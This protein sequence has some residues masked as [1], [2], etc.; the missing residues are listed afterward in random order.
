MFYLNK[1]RKR[2]KIGIAIS[3][4]LFTFWLFSLPEPLFNAPCSTV[5]LDNDGQLM[6]ARLAA[7]GQWRFPIPDSTPHKM[8]QCILTFEDKWFRKHPGVNLISLFRATKQNIQSG[9]IVSGG[10]TL[11]MQVIRLS[12]KDKKR[13]FLE[14]FIEMALAL[15]L[16]LRY[17]KDEILNLY[18]TNAPFGGNTVGIQTASWRYFGRDCKDLSWAEASTLAVLPN[19]PALIHPGKNRDR[20]LRKRNRLLAK[21]QKEGIIDEETC[22]LAISEPLPE[23]PKSL[24]KMA[25]HL[26]DRIA[27]RDN[28]QIIR[29]TIDGHLQQKIESTVSYFHDIYT[30]NQVQNMA[31]VVARTGTG[32]VV[33][34]CGNA[35]YDEHDNNHVDIITSP[36]STGSTLKPFLYNAILEEGTL[37]PK[38]LIPDIPI[39]IAGYRPNN[40]ERKFDGA[41]P[42]NEALARS[43]NIPAVLML[44][45]YGIPKFMDYLK[46]AGMTTLH[47]S[48]DHYGLTL[49]LGGAEGT[50]WN[51]TGMY[52]NMTRTLLNYEKSF[53]YSEDDIH[54]LY[55]DQKN[56]AKTERKTQR[57]PVLF[58]AQ[59][60]W[61]TLDAI[62][63][64][65]RPGVTDWRAFNSSRRVGWKTGTSF[66]NKDAWAIGVTP[67]Y[68]VGVWIGN[69]DGEGRPGVTG[70]TYAA[71]VM[72]SIFNQLPATSWF[73]QPSKDMVEI[74]VCPQS[75]YRRGP[76]CPSGETVSVYKTQ[77][78]CEACPFHHIV[79]LSPDRKYRVTSTCM[80]VTEMRHE[81]WFTLPPSMEWYYKQHNTEYKSQPPYKE[82]CRAR[83][84]ASP[85]EFIYPKEDSKLFIPIDLD[86]KKSEIIF[87]IAHQD[88]N[89]IL[90]W[91][92]DKDYLGSTTR[93]HQKG[94]NAEI[95]KHIMTVTDNNGNAI[96]KRFEIVN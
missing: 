65:N 81:K 36:R 34:Y 42:A 50:L 95:G 76:N 83:N 79:H 43:L 70:V 47:Y 3:F 94:I 11:S 62:K 45:D 39:L 28:R 24:Q 61:Q 82:G 69:A 56:K 85:M 59:A 86:G 72:F 6:G 18:L 55:F 46:K 57:Q 21:L 44:R 87:E 2:Y 71:P 91:H 53:N 64:L 77:T 84:E 9:H 27:R 51:L 20:L 73:N 40:F 17:T 68:V 14:K 48:A 54:P 89:A 15:R 52:A 13:T 38:T 60:V 30:Q 25:P 4:V 33:A 22:R 66:G 12:R 41:V 96:S 7:D 8:E 93:Y 23:K 49:I 29:S 58:H 92:L 78:K 26:I 19:S 5:V 35:G 16:E 88:K 63:E 10:S 32:E 90:Y 31:V 37:L 74:E 75:G 80:P 1:I 67:E